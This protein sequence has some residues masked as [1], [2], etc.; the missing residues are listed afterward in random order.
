[1]RQVPVRQFLLKVS[2]RCNLACDYCYVYRHADQSWR[3]QPKVMSKEIVD[4]A[5]AR[6]A[7]HALKHD[8]PLVVVILHGG[9]PLLAGVDTIEYVAST[10][11]RELGRVRVALGVQTNG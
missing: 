11:R 6:I 4:L 9:E 2:S 10:V 5:V 8:L 3:H 7:E 1:M